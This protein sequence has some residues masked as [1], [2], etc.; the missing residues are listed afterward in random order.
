MR[1][2][3]LTVGRL[4]RGGG[5][6]DLAARYRERF[7]AAGRQIGLGPLTEIELAESKAGDADARR[8]EEAQ[9]LL[10]RA[11]D[12]ARRIVLD[13]GGRVMS[14][15]AFAKMIGRL[16][17]DGIAQAAFFIGGP[18]GHGA[19]LLDKSDERLSLGAMTLPHGLARVVLLEQ[20]YRAVTILSGHPYHRA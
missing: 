14:S 9:R 11:D 4:K 17:D 19:A 10:L 6:A 18:D 20:L 12:S 2:K 5:E 1:V 16:R 15:T 3:L 7:D 13:E 8:E